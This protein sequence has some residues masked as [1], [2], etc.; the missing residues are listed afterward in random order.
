M[1]AA[2]GQAREIETK[3][4]YNRFSFWT[5]NGKQ[6]IFMGGDRGGGG[7]VLWRIAKPDSP[8]T[9][10]TVKGANRV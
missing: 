10:L 7:S 5:E 3:L 4:Q 2:G 9:I 6:L 1:P 8:E